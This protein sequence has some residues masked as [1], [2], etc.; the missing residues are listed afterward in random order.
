CLLGELFDGDAANPKPPIGALAPSI[1][2]AAALPLPVVKGDRI[3]ISMP[4]E[5]YQVGLASC[6]HNLHGRII[7]P[8]GSTPLK[9]AEVKSKLSPLWKTL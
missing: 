6:K 9:V 1:I 7:W 2:G 4:D 5:E 8:K 3:S